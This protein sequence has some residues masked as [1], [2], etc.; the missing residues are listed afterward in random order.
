MAKKTSFPRQPAGFIDT[1]DCLPVPRL[2]EGPQWSYEIKL[3]GYRLEVV[4]SA[5]RTTFYFRRQNVLNQ[6]FRYIAPA[7]EDLPDDTVIDG[8]LVALGPDGR[9]GL[10]SSAGLPLRRT[11]QGRRMKYTSCAMVV[12][13]LLA[14]KRD[15]QLSRE[16]KKLA[17]YDGLIIDEVGYLQQSREEI[18]VLFTLLAER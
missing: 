8:E 10:Q 17:S 1:M 16:I 15:L 12:Q 4:R 5:G 13:D 9:P 7:L 18:E 11:A 14:A 6:R 2:P 3:D